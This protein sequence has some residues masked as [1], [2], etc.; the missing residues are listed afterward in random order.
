MQPAQG[1]LRV[2]R[3]VHD[4]PSVAWQY[5]RPS[6][7]RAA[8]TTRITQ[9]P[10]YYTSK[11]RVTPSPLI[12][13]PDDIITRAPRRLRKCT[14]ILHRLRYHH[15]PLIQLLFCYNS[16]AIQK[17][18]YGR[19]SFRASEGNEDVFCRRA[20]NMHRDERATNARA[21]HG[22]VLSNRSKQM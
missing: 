4:A 18:N 6:C 7:A 3:K 13:L 21:A 5:Q 1:A 8:I 2:C 14:P 17:V 10:Y 20:P 16:R 15:L 12:Y 9:Q 22:A 11:L 19:L